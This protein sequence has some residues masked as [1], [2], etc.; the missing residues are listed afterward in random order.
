M[1]INKNNIQ[2]KDRLIVALDVPDE[3]TALSLVDKIGDSVGF[4]KIGLELFASGFGRGLIDTLK[5]MGHRV[6]VDIK[7]YDIPET[8][9]RAVKQISES[10]AD[11]L[12][13]HGDKSI[14]EAAV[15]A[16][17]KSNNGLQI[18]SVTALTSLNKSDIKNLGFECDIG[19]LVKMRVQNAVDCGCHGVICSGGD[20]KSIRDMFGDDLIL[21]TPGVRSVNSPMKHDHKRPSTCDEII[22]NG[23][24]YMVVGRPIR[25]AT[26]PKLAAEGI[27]MEINNAFKT[28]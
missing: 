22:K 5:K 20:I 3:K 23:G 2:N 12:T 18:L 9:S 6:F 10:G 27:I 8:V 19:E 11:F 13:V 16:A 4:Y 21:V 1:K 28:S 15:L 17:D 24:D 7:L 26:D 14:I 25:D